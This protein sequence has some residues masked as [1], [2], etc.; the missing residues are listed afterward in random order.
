[1]VEKKE[2]EREVALVEGG[3]MM[4]RIRRQEIGVGHPARNV[5]ITMDLTIAPVS[6][7]SQ[8]VLFCIVVCVQKFVM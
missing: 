1:M 6:I 4:R 3:M 2:V 8:V 7:L 5:L